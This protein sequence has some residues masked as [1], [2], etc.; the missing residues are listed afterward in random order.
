MD[1]D[2][3]AFGAH[4]DDVELACGGTLIGRSDF[5]ESIETRRAFSRPG[6]H[7]DQG[8]GGILRAGGIMGKA[9]GILNSGLEGGGFVP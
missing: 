3:L 2:A 9:V 1:L 6:R 8:S 5:L 4:G 7:H